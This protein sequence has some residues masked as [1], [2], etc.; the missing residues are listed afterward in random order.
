MRN[1]VR[2]S[3]ILVVALGVLTFVAYSALVDRTR[4]W[5]ESDVVLRAQLV[6]ASARQS[7]ASHWAK[8]DE[9]SLGEVLGDIAR[10]R[11]IMAV[12]ACGAQGETK[13][14]T[15]SF[16]ESFACPSLDAS[17]RALG[18]DFDKVD[19]HDVLW[20]RA[21]LPGGPVLVAAAPLFDGPRRIG[22]LVLIHDLSFVSRRDE[23][24]RDLLL[25]SFFV[26]ATAASAITLIAARLSRRSWT[27]ELR[28]MLRGEREEP[29]DYEPLMKDVR[30]LAERLSGEHEPEPRAG[31]WTPERLKATLSQHLRG[32]RIVIV[33]NREPYIH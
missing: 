21:D 33:A 18:V 7:L 2:L 22:R 4:T 12:A 20:S 31:M 25:L 8:G 28:G 32:E 11:R 3:V 16:P 14:T 29:P 10:D 5:F 15:E 1:I 19:E 26:L 23:A 24:A 6:A 13:A 30:D 27:A 17:M 9:S